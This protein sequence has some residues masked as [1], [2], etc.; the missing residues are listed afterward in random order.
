[1]FQVL[2]TY[3]TLGEQVYAKADTLE[4]ALKLKA[5]AKS[6]G[7]TDAVVVRAEPPPPRT[8]K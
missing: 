2:V 6:V 5:T 7:Y 1:M 3:G 4:N 8:K